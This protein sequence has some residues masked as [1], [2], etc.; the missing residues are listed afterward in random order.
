MWKALGQAVVTQRATSIRPG[1]SIVAPGSFKLSS[2][3]MLY[4]I[5]YREKESLQLVARERINT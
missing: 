4:L 3:E 5:F 2:V 1:L